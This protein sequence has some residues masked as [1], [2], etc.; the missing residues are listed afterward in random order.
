MN[1]SELLQAFREDVP[2]RFGGLVFSRIAS[3]IYKR[4]LYN[5]YVESAT[6]DG[7]KT[8]LFVPTELKIIQAVCEDMRG[9][10]YVINPNRLDTASVDEVNVPSDVDYILS[11]RMKLL[12][13][14]YDWCEQEQ[15]DRT[16]H[17]MIL[18]M[19][20]E[21]LIDAGKAYHIVKAFEQ[22]K[23]HINEPL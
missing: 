18:F 12:D 5:Q 23:G 19:F 10:Q 13:V 21:A 15:L 6:I 17:S 11:E 9:N 4:T 14:F 3:V 22:K 16:P 1:S 8:G 2:V 7:A 20:A